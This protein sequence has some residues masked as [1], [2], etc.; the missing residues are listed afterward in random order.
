MLTLEVF[1]YC[2]GSDTDDTSDTG[3]ASETGSDTRDSREPGTELVK[4]CLKAEQIPA[5]L[6]EVP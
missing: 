5:T 4:T 3:D 1:S 6:T 2:R